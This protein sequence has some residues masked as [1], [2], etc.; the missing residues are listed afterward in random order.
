MEV[1]ANEIAYAKRVIFSLDLENTFSNTRSAKG[2]LHY[3][4]QTWR[5]VG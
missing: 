2:Q 1:F 3:L 5:W 4:Y